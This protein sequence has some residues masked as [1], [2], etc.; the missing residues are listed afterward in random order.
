MRRAGRGGRLRAHPAPLA[1]RFAPAAL[2][3]LLASASHAQVL[4]SHPAPPPSPFAGGAAPREVS[5]SEA[6][7]YSAVATGGAVALGYVLYRVLPGDPTQDSFT[8]R[9]LGLALIAVGVVGGPSVGNLT[10]GAENDVNRA[11]LV[12][13]IGAG[14]GAGLAVAAIATCFSIGDSPPAC[15]S[16]G[17]PLFVGAALAVGTGFVVGTVYDLATIPGN[18]RAARRGGVAV[19]LGRGGVPTVGLHVGL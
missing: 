15:E 16:L 8:G 6:Y 11:L 5:A 14:V 10:L 13:G 17:T 1:M 7:L 9:D 19:G 3:L 4:A 2:A 12:K 18:A